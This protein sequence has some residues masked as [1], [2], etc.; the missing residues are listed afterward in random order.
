[1][2]G[3]IAQIKRQ[4]LEEWIKRHDLTRW[5]LQETHFRSSDINKFQGIGYEKI[6]LLIATNREMLWLH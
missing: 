1:M 3:L 6:P 4:R 5:Y 2:N